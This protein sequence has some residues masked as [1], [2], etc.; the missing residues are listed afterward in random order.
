MPKRQPRI[1]AQEL[2]KRI[3]AQ[4]PPVDLERA[5]K[6]LGAVI[7]AKKLPASTSGMLLR[8]G[9]ATVIGVNITDPEVRRRFSIAHE[10]G[11][12]SLHPGRP[13]LL[14]EK[15]RVNF[16][17]PLSSTATDSEEIEANA[18]A[19]ELLMPES[20]MRQAVAKL[21]KA[22]RKALVKRLAEDFHVSR[23]AME[24]RLVNLGVLLPD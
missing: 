3:K 12:L 1:A 13:L 8:T 20:L 24:I 2:L 15:V 7:V 16:R 4:R 9:D 14:H 11:H 23:Q 21:P 19:A 22:D 17:D 10:L 6:L 5:A 18:F